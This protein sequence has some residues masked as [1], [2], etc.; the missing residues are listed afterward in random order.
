[1]RCAEA[2]VTRKEQALAIA[3]YDQLRALPDAPHQ[4]RTGAIRG[5]ILT[6][7]RRGLRS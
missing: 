1:M 2:L 3:I 4:V 7:A 6:R 5:A